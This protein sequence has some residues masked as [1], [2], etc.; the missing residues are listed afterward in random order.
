M[1]IDLISFRENTGS[2]RVDAQHLGGI[3]THSIDMWASNHVE[4]AVGVWREWVGDAK[5]KNGENKKKT[6]QKELCLKRNN[7]DVSYK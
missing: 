7:Q 5:C 6:S 3:L 4:M 1:Y 2:I